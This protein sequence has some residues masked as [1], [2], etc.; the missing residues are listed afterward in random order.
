MYGET[1][2]DAIAR[3]SVHGT[4][5]RDDLALAPASGADENVV[6]DGGD[7]RV[8]SSQGQVGPT[9]PQGGCMADVPFEDRD[10]A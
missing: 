8:L 10:A 2:E 7:D 5:A 1:D 3:A 9:L 4:G 6:E